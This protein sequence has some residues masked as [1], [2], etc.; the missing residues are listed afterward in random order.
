D[1][2][3]VSPIVKQLSTQVPNSTILFPLFNTNLTPTTI[4]S[5]S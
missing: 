4:I 5:H 3:S 1:T 2:L